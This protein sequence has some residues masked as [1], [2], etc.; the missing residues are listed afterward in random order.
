MIQNVDQIAIAVDNL[1]DKIRLYTDLL[2]AG[3]DHVEEVESEQV[4]IAM[5]RLGETKIELLEGTGAQSPISSFVTKRGPGVHHIA[6]RVDNI[7]SAIEEYRA[8]GFVF[9]EPAP[10]PGAGGTS[11]AFVHPKSTGG[12]LIELVE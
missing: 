9:I 7:A 5:F 10:R 3:P 4:R 2:G 8:K 6:F 1:E 12:V 11:V